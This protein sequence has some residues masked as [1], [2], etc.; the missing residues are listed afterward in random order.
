MRVNVVS[1]LVGS[2][3]LAKTSSAVNI[4]SSNDDGWAEVNIRAFFD[5]LS[6]NGHSV[7]VSAPAENQSGKGPLSASH[8][9]ALSRLTCVTQVQHKELRQYST[10]LASLTAALPVVPPWGI[11][12]QS[13]V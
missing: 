9:F 11:M 13:L 3:A 1:A 2:L 5:S 4:I 7:V 6:E 12:P 8:H 10:S